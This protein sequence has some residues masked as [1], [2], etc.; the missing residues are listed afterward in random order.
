M[1]DIGDLLRS[2]HLT[3]T[4]L[5]IDLLASQFHVTH[6][7]T[8]VSKSHLNRSSK[9]HGQSGTLDSL[10]ASNLAHLAWQAPSPAQS[11][12]VLRV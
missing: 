3:A 1:V 10:F 2:E 6:L 5:S 11:S 8:Y 7:P 9:A 12:S 4:N